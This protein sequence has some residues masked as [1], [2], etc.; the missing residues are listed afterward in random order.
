MSRPVYWT[1]ARCLDA[2]SEWALNHRGTPP[3]QR[4][5]K[6]AGAGHPCYQTIVQ[7]FGTFGFG[8]ELAGFP[9]RSKPRPYWTK[10]R[11]K[12]ALRAW[13][14]I[15]GRPP[16]AYDWRG[17]TPDHPAHN[18]VMARFGSWNAALAAAGLPT[19][20][21]HG[22]ASSYTQREAVEFL[23]AW[24]QENGRFPTFNEYHYSRV[25]GPAPG[26][27]ARLCGS[28]KNAK[29]LAVHLDQEAA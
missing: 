5:W 23:I 28:W 20:P 11:I 1:K 22:P 26:T 13:N 29:R 6:T 27:I 21:A 16:K 9:R 15:N 8:L 25:G 2:I 3:R 18:A 14:V 4:D 7:R 17:G 19:R 12:L 24:K 10:A